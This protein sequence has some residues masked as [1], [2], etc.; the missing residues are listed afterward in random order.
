MTQMAQICAHLRDPR[1]LRM[2]KPRIF[3]RGSIK[4]PMNLLSQRVTAAMPVMLICRS[5]SNFN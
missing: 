5:Y 2:K 1:H 4:L 3:I